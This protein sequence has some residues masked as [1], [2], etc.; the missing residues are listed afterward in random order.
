MTNTPQL[1]RLRTRML[2]T[3]YSNAD[4][5][6][7]RTAYLTDQ[8]VTAL[9][10]RDPTTAETLAASLMCP[11]PLH[12]TQILDAATDA[13][14]DTSS[15]EERRE[16]TR[17]YTRDAYELSP[18]P[19]PG[20]EATRIWASLYDNYPQVAAALAAF[21]RDM[22]ATWHEDLFTTNPH[23]FAAPQ[24]TS[25]LPAPETAPY[26]PMDW[27]DCPA[28][29]EAQD[30]CRYH[31]GFAAGME[32]QRDLII[33]VLTDHAAIDQLQQRHGELKTKAAHA[34]PGR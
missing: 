32:Y 15:W 30:Q 34:H 25:E 17:T 19:D 1:T 8:A 21:L 12:D 27:E 18:T 28:C 4:F 16:K 11:G 22:P 7:Q 33:T 9:A 31:R 2:A 20:T 23:S 29:A 26:D 24:T 3:A 13:G 14:I 6:V 5:W 10:R